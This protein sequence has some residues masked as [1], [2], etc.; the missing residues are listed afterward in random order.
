MATSTPSLC[1]KKWRDRYTLQS[2]GCEVWERPLAT[3]LNKSRKGALHMKFHLFHLMPYPDLPD[4]FQREVP[5]RSGSTCRSELLRPRARP[6][7]LQRVPRRARVRGGDGLRRH[8]R[9]RA[10]PERLR[11][12]ALAQPHGGGA[13]PRARPTS[14]SSSW[15][16]P[17]RCTTRRRAS[18]KSSRCSTC[19]S[20]GRLVAGFPVG[21]SMDTNYGYGQTPA[22]LRDKYREA[23]D[24]IVRAWTDPEPFAFNGKYTQLRY[25]NIWPRPMQK[26]HPPVWVPGGGSI[27]TWEWLTDNDYLFA[28]L[29]YSGYKRAQD[30]H[31]RLLGV[32]RRAGQGDE[33]VPRRLP[34][35]RR[36]GR[37]R[38][39]GRG[40]LRRGGRVLLR[41]LH[42]RLPRLRRGAGLPLDT[43]APGGLGR[44]LIGS[45][46]RLD[47]SGAQT[48]Q[49]EATTWK[50]ARSSPAA[51]STSRSRSATSR[52][53]CASAT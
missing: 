19:I 10:P 7:D 3:T 2:Y 42:A 38:R 28:Y 14:A 25:V 32:R 5:Q 8:L 45:T 21:T 20:G 34:A 27:E 50:T 51:P 35:V 13:R 33:P 40:R 36:R 6:R 17:W 37:G 47:R 31:G 11:P 29:S 39:A 41:A 1:S 15:A 48:T 43:V 16:T 30:D 9:Q 12:D 49:V 22:T 4:D 46:R 18:P 23:H 53:S 24:L 44:P 26:P 52:T